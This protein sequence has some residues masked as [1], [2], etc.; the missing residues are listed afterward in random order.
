MVVEV[1]KRLRR[2][3]GLLP[4][5]AVNSVK[6]YFSM[7]PSTLPCACHFETQPSYRSKIGRSAVGQDPCLM[8]C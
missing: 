5:F 4:N 8:G 7:L 6:M 1:V 2:A 3:N